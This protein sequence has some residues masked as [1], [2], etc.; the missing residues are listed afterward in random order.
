MPKTKGK[1][2]TIGTAGRKHL[3]GTGISVESIQVNVNGQ[4]AR[5]VMKSK[6]AQEAVN[7][8][9]QAVCDAARYMYGSSTQDVAEWT[10]HPRI[11]RV[12]A[13]AFVD[14]VNYQAILAQRYHQTLEKA[15]WATQGGGAK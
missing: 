10:V 4:G 6:G 14:P 13:H 12:S 9:A 1:M 2:K 5:A 11:L 15:F 7:S 3:M 8:H